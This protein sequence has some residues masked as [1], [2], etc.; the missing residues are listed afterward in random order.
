MSQELKLND[1]NAS[2]R[3]GR[4]LSVDIL[5]A[6]AAL[7]VLLHHV[8]R[9]AEDLSPRLRKYLF[10]PFDFGYVGVILFLVLSGFCIHLAAARRAA[11]GRGFVADWGRFWRRRIYRLYPSYLA[12]IV[13]SMAVYSVVGRKVYN[14]DWLGW[15][16]VLHLLLVHNLFRDYCLG[17]ANGPFWTLG[18]EEQLYALY[19]L[20]IALR[21]RFRLLTVILIAAAV[22]LA[23]QLG[24][25]LA[26][27]PDDWAADYPTMGEPPLALGRWLQWPFGFWLAWVLG[28][29]AAEGYVGLARLPGWCFSYRSALLAV[30]VGFAF[31]PINIWRDRVIVA[32]LPDVRVFADALTGLSP[33]AFALSAFVLLN[34]WVREEQGKAFRDPISRI[35]GW[36]GVMSYS[37]YL[38]HSPSL[39]LLETILPF[40]DTLGATVARYAVYPGACIAL[41]AG[42][43]WLV[44]RHFLTRPTIT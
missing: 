31:A 43:F 30:L 15:D 44:E 7:A 20:Y 9:E 37:L 13:F 29:V 33:L 26:F 10:L 8:P 6:L 24:F 18:L 28:A 34:R 3:K 5:R 32:F 14:G 21:Q 40:G 23:W 36:V 19:A 1:P 22:S 27:G 39:V 12:A 4:L 16:L 41:A 2:P 42:F 35:L 38:T 17:L 25:R 11:A